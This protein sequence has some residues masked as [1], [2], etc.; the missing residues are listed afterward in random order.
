MSSNLSVYTTNFKWQRVIEKTDK[1]RCIIAHEQL[2]AAAILPK[3]T[4]NKAK[5]MQCWTEVV[6]TVGWPDG[7]A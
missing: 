7:M 1:I 6:E 3:R 5:R 2:S 4:R